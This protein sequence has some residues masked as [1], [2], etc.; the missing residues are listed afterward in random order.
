TGAVL[1]RHTGVH[2]FTVGQRKGLGLTEPAADGRPR[3]VLNLEPVSGAV[4]VGNAEEL[5]VSEIE[6]D[7]AVFPDAAPTG[8][9]ECSVQIR[10]H[11]DIAPAVIDVAEDRVHIELREQLRGVAPGQGGVLYRAGHGAGGRVVGSATVGAT[12]RG[13]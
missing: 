11:G 10:A 13:A 7:R 4:T 9:T 2:G 3:Y 6:A 5:A 1:G 12:A 8:P